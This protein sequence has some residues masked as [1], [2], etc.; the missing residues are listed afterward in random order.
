MPS[1]FIY[2]FDLKETVDEIVS[3]K[4][5]VGRRGGSRHVEGLLNIFG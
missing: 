4:K 3:F 2:L 1:P 5:V